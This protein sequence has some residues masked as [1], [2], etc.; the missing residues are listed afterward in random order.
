MKHGKVEQTE[1][2]FDLMHHPKDSA[3][4]VAV[5]YISPCCGMF[6]AQHELMRRKAGAWPDLDQLRT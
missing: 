3:A 1:H 5:H 4:L 2:A 6:D